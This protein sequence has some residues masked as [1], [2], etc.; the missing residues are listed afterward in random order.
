MIHVQQ[1]IQSPLADYSSWIMFPTLSV[2]RIWSEW[3]PGG[4]LSTKRYLPEGLV[5]GKERECLSWFYG[6]LAYNHD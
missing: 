5:Q 2:S 4:L 1:N 6:D 3:L